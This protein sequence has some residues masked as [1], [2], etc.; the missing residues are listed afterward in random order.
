MIKSLLNS[1]IKKDV[2][3]RVPAEVFCSEIW[4]EING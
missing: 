3:L 4:N 2:K 1:R